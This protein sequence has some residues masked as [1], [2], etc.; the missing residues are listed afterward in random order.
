[1]RLLL[2]LLL[3]FGVTTASPA[4]AR[5]DIRID[6]SAQ[7]MTVTRDGAKMAVWKI[8]SGRDGYETPTGVFSVQRMDADHHSDE[9]D[10]APMPFS[11]FFTN[12]VAIHGTYERGLGS[13]RSHGCVRLAVGNARQ[14]FGWVEKY[15]ARIEVDGYA[16]SS[17][18]G[19]ALI[20]DAAPRR[21]PKR[22]RTE[23]PYR[24]EFDQFYTQY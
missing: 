12:G 23:D 3:F 7:R 17:V 2:L 19:N 9:Y 1:M 14:L 6:L 20:E 24:D 8:S 13:P 5:L 16:G 4:F 21:K 15:G 22:R 11:I 10:N 18:I